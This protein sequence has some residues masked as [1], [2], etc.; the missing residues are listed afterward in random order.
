MVYAFDTQTGKFLKKEYNF[1]SLIY[2]NQT[3]IWIITLFF[4]DCSLAPV[5]GDKIIYIYILKKR[6]KQS[7]GILNIKIDHISPTLNIIFY[8]DPF[9]I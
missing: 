9:N 5:H 1:M 8:F 7:F 3:N 4:S 2:Q 6:L